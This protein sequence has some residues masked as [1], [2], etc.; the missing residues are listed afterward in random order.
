MSPV[1]NPRSVSTFED[2]GNDMPL[3]TSSMNRHS[4]VLVLCML[5]PTARFENYRLDPAY[6]PFKMYCFDQ[7]PWASFDLLLRLNYGDR[8][9][10]DPYLRPTSY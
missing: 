3:E 4:M 1:L 7:S 5:V 9:L 10:L 6:G 2:S 8:L